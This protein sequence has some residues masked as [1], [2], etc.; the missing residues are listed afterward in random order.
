MKMTLE[1][2][3]LRNMRCVI[4]EVGCDGVGVLHAA[5]SRRV[6]V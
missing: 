3:E 5:D 1:A 4:Y 2:E 6:C